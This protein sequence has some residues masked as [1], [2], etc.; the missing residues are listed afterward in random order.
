VFVDCARF[1]ENAWFIQQNEPGY[2][3]KLC[4]QI[5][6]EMFSLFDGAMMSMKKDAFGNIGGFLAIGGKLDQV[7][8]GVKNL[9]ILTEGFSTYGGLAGRDLEALAVGIQEILDERYLTYRIT[10]TRYLFEKLDKEKVP[11]LRPCG[12]HAIY[13]DARGFLPHIP[14]AELPGQALA[15]AIYREGGVRSCEI[16][17]V[18]FGHTDK[19]TGLQL[20]STGKDLV[21]LAFPRRVYTQSHYDYL[22]EVIIHIFK[23]RKALIPR[24]L[25]IIREPPYLRHFTCDFE[26]M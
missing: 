24:G 19:E 12:G 9:G 16:G 8:E 1:A 3:K 2:E 18:M 6:Q 10:S 5:A 25:K 11:M 4:K 21:R 13:L 23:H 22:A 7:V 26:S 20:G 14:P 15:V 17:T